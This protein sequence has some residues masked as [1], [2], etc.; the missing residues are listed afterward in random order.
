[1]KEKGKG[2]AVQWGKEK[3]WQVAL[4]Q[5]DVEK[6]RRMWLLKLERNRSQDLLVTVGKK[7]KFE[8]GDCWWGITA[9]CGLGTIRK[10]AALICFGFERERWLLGVS[11][12]A[13]GWLDGKEGGLVGSLVCMPKGDPRHRAPDGAEKATA[14]PCASLTEDSTVKGGALVGFWAQLT[15]R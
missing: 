2:G 5:I 1:L 6:D 9:G 12:R 8:R 10:L 7:R 11:V 13:R 15:R 3:K 4:L 14:R